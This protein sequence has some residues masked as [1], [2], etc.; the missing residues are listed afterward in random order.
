MY[1]ECRRVTHCSCLQDQLLELLA[2]AYQLLAALEDRAKYVENP[3]PKLWQP[4]FPGEEE[5]PS[6]RK[7]QFPQ[8]REDESDNDLDDF[9]R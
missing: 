3:P 6:V 5:M 1:E 4:R 7:I 2:P 8:P 9:R